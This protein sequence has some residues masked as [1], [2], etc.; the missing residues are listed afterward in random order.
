MPPTAR[1]YNLV[2]ARDNNSHLL[3]SFLYGFSDILVEKDLSG[4]DRYASATLP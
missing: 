3:V 1:T 4:R 2:I